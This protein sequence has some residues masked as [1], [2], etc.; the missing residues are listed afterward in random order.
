MKNNL[1]V[2]GV[3]G[4]KNNGKTTMV[5]RLVEEL[6]SRGY[7]ISTVKHAHHDFDIDHE[8]TDS[9]RHRKSGAQE[10]AVVSSRRFALI[11]ENKTEEETPLST[12]LDLLS[13]CDLVIVE[14]Y[15]RDKHDKLEVRRNGG[16]I[17][18]PLNKSDPHIVAIAS[19]EPVA[20]KHLPYFNIDDVAAIADFIVK[21]MK[22]EQKQEA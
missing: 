15:K 9:W 2:F 22:L 8:N 17:G 3:T 20:E 18:E 12:I 19:D 5:V 16:K 1:K 4:W 21:H 7:K 13:P 6:T 10:V 14:G 11:H